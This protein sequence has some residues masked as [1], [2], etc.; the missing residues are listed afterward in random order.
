MTTTPVDIKAHTRDAVLEIVWDDGQVSRLPYAFL[1]GECQ[2]AGCV[3]EITRER[4]LDPATI[5]P[6]IKIEDLQL[7]GSYAVRIGWSDGHAT[8]LYTWQFLRQLDPPAG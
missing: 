1:R 7:V 6:D 8:G 3:H 4:L 5:P 2:C